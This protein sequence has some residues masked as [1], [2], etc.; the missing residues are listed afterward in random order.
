[1]TRRNATRPIYEAQ[2]F[3]FDPPRRLPR[4]LFIV[5]VLLAIGAVAWGQEPETCG[6]SLEEI[7]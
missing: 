2:D 1:M 3:T 6:M 4:W 5:A 7:E